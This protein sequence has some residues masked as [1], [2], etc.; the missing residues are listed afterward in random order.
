MKKFKLQL[1]QGAESISFGSN[2]WKGENGHIIVEEEFASHLILHAG[3]KMVGEHKEGV[4]GHPAK[5]EQPEST[6]H[7]SEGNAKVVKTQK[8]AA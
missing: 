5:A 3:C 8:K 4:T 7:S 6:Q 1:P 2:K